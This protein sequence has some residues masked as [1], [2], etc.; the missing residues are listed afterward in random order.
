VPAAD[1]HVRTAT[2]LAVDFHANMLHD[3]AFG[4]LEMQLVDAA[5]GIAGNWLS[6]PGT[7]VRAPAVSQIACPPTTDGMCRLYGT[8][9]DAIA[10]VKDMSGSFVAPELDCPPTEKGDGCVYVPH[11]AHYV[12]R[13]ID[14]STIETLADALIA[15]AS[16]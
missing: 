10:A 14:A 11:V 4:T 9:L 15:T 1:V 2:T 6:L 16:Q 8:D 5:S 3:R 13:L 12:L 7:F